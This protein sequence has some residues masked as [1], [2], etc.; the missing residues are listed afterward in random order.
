[1]LTTKAMNEAR[2]A[3]SR[4]AETRALLRAVLF[5]AVAAIVTTAWGAGVRKRIQ[6]PRARTSVVLAGSVVRGDRNEYLLGARAGQQMTVRVTAAENNV[7][8]QIY[9]P[10]KSGKASEN[11]ALAGA[12]VLDDARRWRGRLPASGDYTIVVGPT[13]GNANYRLKVTIQ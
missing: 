9:R 10:G 8:F 2:T 3:A 7:V 12:G 4:A 11:N 6:F 13:R 5:L 1:M